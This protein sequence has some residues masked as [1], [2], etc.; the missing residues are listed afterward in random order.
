MS[1]HRRIRPLLKHFQVSH[2]TAIAIVALMTACQRISNDYE[3]TMMLCGKPASGLNF[4]NSNAYRPVNLKSSLISKPDLK[5]YWVTYD[6]TRTTLDFSSKGCVYVPKVNEG[7]LGFI[8]Q[9]EGLF[10]VSHQKADQSLATVQDT[11]MEQFPQLT[12]KL[13]CSGQDIW[14]NEPFVDLTWEIT[15]A[16]KQLTLADLRNYWP[17][18]QLRF[19]SRNQAGALDQELTLTHQ[20]ALNL[21]QISENDPKFG[22]Q[23]HV[24]Q[25]QDSSI[26]LQFQDLLDRKQLI[27][28]GAACK[29]HHSLKSPVLNSFV[30]NEKALRIF[31]G[32]TV[33]LE[34][35][36]GAQLYMQVEPLH[37]ES[38]VAKWEFLSAAKQETEL[39]KFRNG[40]MPIFWQEGSYLLRA[41]TLSREGN[42]S[43]IWE[44]VVQVN[45]S[46]M[47]EKKITAHHWVL[48]QVSP[49]SKAGLL[50]VSRESGRPTISIYDLAAAGE[51]TAEIWQPN[52]MPASLGLFESGFGINRQIVEGRFGIGASNRQ[53]FCLSRGSNPSDAYRE[54]FQSRIFCW[55]R[56]EDRSFKVILDQD[57]PFWNDDELTAANFFGDEKP[58]ILA[59]SSQDGIFRVFSLI[60]S[61]PMQVNFKQEISYSMEQNRGIQGSQIDAVEETPQ[62]TYLYWIDRSNGYGV[63][64]SLTNNPGA[65]NNGQL[66]MT[67]RSPSEINLSLDQWGVTSPDETRLPTTY[68]RWRQ[69][70]QVLPAWTEKHFSLVFHDG[71][72]NR[73]WATGQR[74]LDN[75][76]APLINSIRW[77]GL[78]S[79]TTDFCYFYPRSDGA[80]P[81]TLDDPWM[82]CLAFGTDAHLRDKAQIFRYNRDKKI[83]SQTAD[84]DLSPPEVGQFK[85]FENPRAVQEIVIIPSLQPYVASSEDLNWAVLPLEGSEVLP[86]WEQLNSEQ[87]EKLRQG[88][89]QLELWGNDQRFAAWLWSGALGKP[90]ARELRF[91][92]PI[93]ASA[94]LGRNL[95]LVDLRADGRPHLVQPF[96]EGFA[97]LDI[98]EPDSK[99]LKHL[100]VSAP[101][102]VQ[103]NP[104]GWNGRSI[105]LLSGRVLPDLEGGVFCYV[106]RASQSLGKAGQISCYGY[107]K[108]RETKIAKIFEGDFPVEGQEQ[109]SAIKIEGTD[110]TAIAVFNPHTNKI[111]VHTLQLA[112]S[113][114]L[115]VYKAK[116]VPWVSVTKDEANQDKIESSDAFTVMDDPVRNT[117]HLGTYSDLEE[118]IL[119]FSTQLQL[120]QGESRWA[121]TTTVTGETVGGKLKKAE[122]E[123]LSISLNPQD[124]SLDL[125]NYHRPDL[126]NS[127]RLDW[128]KVYD[129]RTVISPNKSKGF[130][131]NTGV[132]K[133]DEKGVGYCIAM[134]NLTDGA[135]NA[136]YHPACAF[137]AVQT[138]T[139]FAGLF[140]TLTGITE[141]Y[142]TQP[143]RLDTHW[144]FPFWRNQSNNPEHK[145]GLMTNLYAL[146]IPK[147]LSDDGWEVQASAVVDMPLSFYGQT[148]NKHRQFS[149]RLEP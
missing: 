148:W 43:P 105:S 133:F 139:F 111:T 18:L 71:A 57:A 90:I 126:F 25:E 54:P 95:G 109:V 129:S 132:T 48:T 123:E 99:W 103:D 94:D 98:S 125:F 142:V 128:P 145:A 134:G 87:K 12:A 66:Q 53:Q 146:R 79:S 9:A 14:T 23:I 121:V 122:L 46:N 144:T 85:P 28:G 119:H 52:V 50:K 108:L 64:S 86:L 16:G 89:G 37:V 135:V 73:R 72:L 88:Q 51:I 81:T 20:A 1:I 30:I 65:S 10:A 41:F 76:N 45:E 68:A 26:E 59:H 13:S 82:D 93:S 55:E 70:L 63:V 60:P 39:K 115:R 97:S 6:G 61:A 35:P 69:R 7:S 100:G 11:V 42:R 58:E 83:W 4:G 131:T 101:N 147:N 117:L 21:Q 84:I 31:R 29:V 17:L 137:F 96:E 78:P 80:Q 24:A 106:A 47:V 130:Y 40:R 112:Q 22:L 140:N 110:E 32:Q 67:Y 113:T 49:S 27:E 107:Q 114:P 104:L 74:T 56:Q 8:D 5:A 92:G 102:F 124:L 118:G 75:P 116:L 44:R 143:D 15:Q 33:H 3:S 62:K 2:L 138:E 38:K 127:Q 77:N 149:L 34:A 141:D 19:Q 136:Y 36:E 120:G 91:A